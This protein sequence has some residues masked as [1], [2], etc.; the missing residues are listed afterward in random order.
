MVSR[1]TASQSYFGAGPSP[2]AA[3]VLLEFY[4]GFSAVGKSRRVPSSSTRRHGIEGRNAP[5][6]LAGPH[7]HLLALDGSDLDLELLPEH[8]ES[9]VRERIIGVAASSATTAPSPRTRPLAHVP[10]C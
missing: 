6:R 4:Y 7:S 3:K 2:S 5:W 10:R 8:T 1:M 9:I